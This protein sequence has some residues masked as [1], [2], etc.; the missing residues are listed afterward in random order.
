MALEVHNNAPFCGRGYSRRDQFKDIKYLTLRT[1]TPV[2]YELKKTSFSYC[3]YN[4]P[5]IESILSTRQDE[6]PLEDEIENAQ[7]VP[8]HKNIRGRDYYN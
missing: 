6:V 5:S 2:N 4:Y 8:I 7:E 1:L 3:L